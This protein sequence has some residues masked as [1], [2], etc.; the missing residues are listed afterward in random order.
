[1]GHSTEAASQKIKD[2]L[3]S[4]YFDVDIS[5][6]FWTVFSDTTSA[7][8]NVVDNFDDTS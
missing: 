2:L 1:M 7:A 6:H 8:Q 3:L 5:E 4:K